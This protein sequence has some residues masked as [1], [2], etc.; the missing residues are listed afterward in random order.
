[1]GEKLP[2][3]LH[4]PFGLNRCWIRIILCL[5]H[6]DYYLNLSD[7]K[8]YKKVCNFNK[9]PQVASISPMMLQRRDVPSWPTSRLTLD[10]A[11]NRP[12]DKHEPIYMWTKPNFNIFIFMTKIRNTVK[13]FREGELVYKLLNFIYSPYFLKFSHSRVCFIH[14]IE[15]RGA[16]LS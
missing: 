11:A 2:Y 16:S 14:R 12:Y 15:R 13:Y 3:T 7:W 4:Y 1:M 8:N 5:K 6:L 10:T 9:W